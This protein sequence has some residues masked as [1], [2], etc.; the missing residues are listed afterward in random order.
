MLMPDSIYL[1]E[2]FPWLFDRSGCIGLRGD[3]AYF[4]SICVFL[5]RDLRLTSTRF[6]SYFHAI[7]FLLPRDLR[8]TSTRFASYCHTQHLSYILSVYILNLWHSSVLLT[9]DLRIS[10]KRL[11]SYCHKTWVL[12]PHDLRLTATRFASYCEYD[13]RLTYRGLNCIL[14]LHDLRLTATRHVSACHTTYCNKTVK[15]IHAS[16]Y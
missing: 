16:I 15:K 6:A 3:E 14:V 2:L 8:L 9:R 10:T 13:V 4:H 7:C 5:T 11:A 1:A 12:L